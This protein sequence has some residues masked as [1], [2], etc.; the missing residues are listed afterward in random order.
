MTEDNGLT[1][2]PAL[3]EDFRAVLRGVVQVTVT[4]PV[5]YGWIEQM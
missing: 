2:V 3:A 1:G 4:D 5:M